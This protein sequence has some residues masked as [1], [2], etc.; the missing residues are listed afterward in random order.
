MKRLKRE[1]DERTKLKREK[2]EIERRRN[3]TDEQRI[4]EDFKLG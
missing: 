4:E 2:E 1:Y 3:L